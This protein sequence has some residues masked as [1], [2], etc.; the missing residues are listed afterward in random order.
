MDVVNK[1]FKDFLKN[2]TLN[3]CFVEF[4][5]REWVFAVGSIIFS[6]SFIRGYKVFCII[7][8]LGGS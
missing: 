7:D 5:N 3:G 1:F 8:D 4:M 2:N 6:D